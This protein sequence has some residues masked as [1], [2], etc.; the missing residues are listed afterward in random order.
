MVTGV[1][2]E[3]HQVIGA[4]F[5]MER[6]L[7][8]KPGGDE[9]AR[10]R[11]GSVVSALRNDSGQLRSG[12][13]RLVANQDGSFQMR[14]GHSLL[15]KSEQARARDY[16]LQTIRDAYGDV[17]GMDQA[18]RRYLSS[19][20]SGGK[21]GTVSTLKLIQSLEQMRLK[22]TGQSEGQSDLLDQASALSVGAGKTGRL[23]T[24][25]VASAQASWK[26]TE[27]LSQGWAKLAP[28]VHS[29]HLDINQ[30][31]KKRD[32]SAEDR[33]ALMEKGMAL[34]KEFRPLQPLKKNDPDFALKQA[35]LTTPE[36]QEMTDQLRAAEWKI[37][38]LVLTQSNAD[39]Q[40]KYHGIQA[41]QDHSALRQELVESLAL[42]QG[43][44]KEVEA[45]SSEPAMK[46][47]DKRLPG[48]QT[49]S[50]QLK[51]ALSDTIQI[52]KAGIKKID[53]LPQPVRED[54]DATYFLDSH[55]QFIDMFRR[56]EAEEKAGS[57][58]KS[59]SQTEGTS[60]V[61]R[62]KPFEMKS[63]HSSS[64][65]SSEQSHESVPFAED[66]MQFITGF[67]LP[68]GNFEYRNPW[69][70]QTSSDKKADF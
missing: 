17:P 38:M 32:L 30:A 25:F 4:Q 64:E 61:G 41:G 23:A 15:G 43:L 51:Q 12:Y 10:A 50:T 2:I 36:G 22:T 58:G 3:G 8:S 14:A 45:N 13:L 29:L 16:V 7:A 44:T 1:R 46:A 35:W 63:D 57:A 39:L 40:A 53:D 52:V 65:E 70:P 54:S 11:L 34:T 18:I 28:R 69:A 9:S 67:V 55:P 62:K 27:H 5:R 48:S 59:P 6:D 21:L 49:L 68:G 56:F 47:M 60:D 66:F 19:G 33:K 31:L 37:T 20:Q 42:F 26:Q 24:D